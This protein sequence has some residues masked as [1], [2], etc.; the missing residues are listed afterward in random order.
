MASCGH[1][2][3]EGVQI[4]PLLGSFRPAI[5]IVSGHHVGAQR[6]CV[7]VVTEAGIVHTKSREPVA[8]LH[9][10]DAVQ[11][12]AAD[13]RVGE[14]RQ[15]RGEMTPFTERKRYRECGRTYT[16]PGTIARW[17]IACPVLPE[18]RCTGSNRC[19]CSAAMCPGGT[20]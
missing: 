8:R 14:G 16:K 15:V 17:R 7:A 19:C 11:F 5:G 2:H 20:D 18:G 1:I 12:P 13:E 3:V 4:E 9:R 6:A 10:P